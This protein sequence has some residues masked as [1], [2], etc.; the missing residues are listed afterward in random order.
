MPAAAFTVCALRLAARATGQRHYQRILMGKLG[1]KDG[2]G[3]PHYCSSLSSWRCSSSV[4]GIT[5]GYEKRWAWPISMDEGTLPA[6]RP[7]AEEI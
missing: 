1:A 5:A 3:L 4:P 6:N 7:R 2:S